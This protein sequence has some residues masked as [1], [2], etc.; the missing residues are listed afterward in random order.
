MTAQ[1]IPTRSAFYST[2][3]PPYKSEFY[4]NSFTPYT[5]SIR[6]SKSSSSYI[7]TSKQNHT[8][9]TLT[10]P[11]ELH[12]GSSEWP[13]YRQERVLSYDQTSDGKY[14]KEPKI[15]SQKDL[16]HQRRTAT[17]TSITGPKGQQISAG[18]SEYPRN[19]GEQNDADSINGRSK[20][21]STGLHDR[22]KRDRQESLLATLRTHETISQSNSHVF[23]PKTDL[24]ESFVTQRA[25]SAMEHPLT[26]QNY[27]SR[28]GDMK[29]RE[30]PVRRSMSSMDTTDTRFETTNQHFQANSTLRASADIPRTYSVTQSGGRRSISHFGL[31][32]KDWDRNIAAAEALQQ[33]GIETMTRGT[34]TSELRLIDAIVERERS[35]PF[36]MNDDPPLFSSFSVDQTFHPRVL[37]EWDGGKLIRRRKDKWDRQR[38]KREMKESL[39][40]SQTLPRN[41]SKPPQQSIFTVTV[42][43]DP[44]DLFDTSP[45]V[46][47]SSSSAPESMGSSAVISPRP[48]FLKP[49]EEKSRKRL[50]IGMATQNLRHGSMNFEDHE[51]TEQLSRITGL[52][53][54]EVERRSKKITNSRST[55][56]FPTADDEEQTQ[57]HA[58]VLEEVSEKMLRSP[59]VESLR[60]PKATSAYQSYRASLAPNPGRGEGKS[61]LQSVSTMSGER[62]FESDNDWDD[63]AHELLMLSTTNSGTMNT[64]ATSFLLPSNPFN[65]LYPS[66]KRQR[67]NE[68]R[69]QCRDTLKIRKDGTA[70]ICDET[71]GDVGGFMFHKNPH[72]ILL[73]Q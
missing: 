9:P 45:Q 47:I 17:S 41:F 63:K 61:P 10:K 1:S 50:S 70:Q 40:K 73:F 13:Y 52:P 15:V 65:P 67:M 19:F 14:S 12:P 71:T 54:H 58:I 39:R 72:S 36:M 35:R 44:D 59:P 23:L 42:D 28:T 53:K 46:V 43:Q 4:S 7:D 21:T 33:T 20:L 69:T 32:K 57:E 11:D 37:P 49:V 22:R 31:S 48:S 60:S 27:R 56:L 64:T 29:I 8:L 2:D 30:N 34:D 55:I 24:P 68:S 18:K 51:E 26:S 3:Y 62:P 16:I 66:T 25:I 5:T 6:Y 38:D